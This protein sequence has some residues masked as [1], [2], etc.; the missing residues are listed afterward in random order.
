MWEPFCVLTSFGLNCLFQKY[1][2]VFF[3]TFPLESWLRTFVKLLTWHSPTHNSLGTLG[4]THGSGVESIPD[5]VC[6]TNV[7]LSNRNRVSYVE[8]ALGDCR[9]VVMLSTSQ[10][11]FFWLVVCPP[12]CVQKQF[13]LHCWLCPLK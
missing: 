12:S 11:L 7:I 13:C 3:F 8:R 4:F 10:A 9:L 6:W 2:I 1:V 5:M